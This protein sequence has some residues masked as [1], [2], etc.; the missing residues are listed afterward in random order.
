MQKAKQT[1]TGQKMTETEPNSRTFTES[2]PTRQAEML[3]NIPDVN[4]DQKVFLR[5]NELIETSKKNLHAKMM[6][7]IKKVQ[8]KEESRNE[9]IKLMMSEDS[10]MKKDS[11]ILTMIEKKHFRER[12]LDR[13]KLNEK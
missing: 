13:A 11:N 9:I 12:Q 2:A 3:P 5:Q 10:E 7:S 1:P 6:K 8:E 4:D